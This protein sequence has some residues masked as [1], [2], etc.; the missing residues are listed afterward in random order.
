MNHHHR[1]LHFSVSL[2]VTKLVIFARRPSL[3]CHHH[4]HSNVLSCCRFPS[5]HRST[6]QNVEKMK[7]LT[8][9]SSSLSSEVVNL[10]LWER[11]WFACAN[12]IS[13][14]RGTLLL[15]DFFSHLRSLVKDNIIALGNVFCD[16]NDWLEALEVD[17]ISLGIPATHSKMEMRNFNWVN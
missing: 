5:C 8:R 17:M 13:V 2:G 4:R 1:S 7:M 6:I 12:Y 10:K 14:H 3:H 16:L 15:K 9:S 11:D